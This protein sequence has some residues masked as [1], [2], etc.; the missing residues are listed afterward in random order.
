MNFSTTL[1]LIF[2]LST[3]TSFKGQILVS[4][5]VFSGHWKETVTSRD[6]LEIR[7]PP[8][9]D[10]NK[11]SGYPNSIIKSTKKHQCPPGKHPQTTHC[12]DFCFPDFFRIKVQN[13]IYIEFARD[14]PISM[15]SIVQTHVNIYI[16]D[17]TICFLLVNWCHD[18][19][20]PKIDITHQQLSFF[21][22][23]LNVFQNPVTSGISFQQIS[24][25]KP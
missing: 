8:K 20:V 12:K 7:I 16:Y 19:Y 15:I 5:Q 6:F 18:Y 22:S 25:P 13:Q 3:V 4:W 11:T 9:T 14:N 21:F 17:Y 23:H 24:P 2:V 1:I 10:T